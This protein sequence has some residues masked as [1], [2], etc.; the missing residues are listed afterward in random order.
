MDIKITPLILGTSAIGGWNWGGS[1]K[2]NDFEAIQ[3]SIDQGVTTLDTAPIYGMGRSEE[4]VGKAIQGRRHEVVI[5]SKCGLRWDSSEGSDPRIQKN[6]Q[7]EIVVSRRNSQPESIAYECEQSLN[8]LGTDYIDLYQI[9]WPDST[10]PI[11]ESWEAMVKLK[12]QG[13]VRAIGVSNYTLQ[14]LAIA[15][16]IH[17]VDSI[18]L[19]FSF[20]RTEIEQEIVPFCIKNSIAVLVYTP[21]ERGLLT[22]KM[23]PYRQF[24]PDDQRSSLPIF[25][26]EIRQVILEVFR[27]L[28]PI[29][30]KYR[31]T[32]AQLV[33]SALI[34]K[35][36]ITG[37]IAGARNREQAIENANS[38][39]ALLTDM[40]VYQIEET[41]K[42]REKL[43]IIQ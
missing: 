40:E 42:Q 32:L 6:M 29:A 39:K 15:H 31:I 20:I 8:R 28:Q 2:N 9:H 35:K 7:G 14:Q 19:P 1:D 3:T 41:F 36:W 17:P 30:D 22:G 38:R 16:S 33:L 5:A 4:L 43:W 34:S 11:E 23:S 25:T 26:V 21:L 12:R 10:T 27:Q 24:L 13:K 18:Q 37:V